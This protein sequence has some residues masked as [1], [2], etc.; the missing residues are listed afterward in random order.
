MKT[1]IFSRFLLSGLVISAAS[2][3]P[4]E[5][6]DREDLSK[7]W[8]MKTPEACNF[9]DFSESCLCGYDGKE[10]PYQSHQ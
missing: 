9:S 10:T 1:A 6:A 7:C 5:L 4:G 2:A 3:A 8:I